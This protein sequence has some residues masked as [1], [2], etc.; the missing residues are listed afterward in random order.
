MIS[1]NDKGMQLF[2]W[3][4]SDLLWNFMESGYH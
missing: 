4:D 2:S 1:K 3:E